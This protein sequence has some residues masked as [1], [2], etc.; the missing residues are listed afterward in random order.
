MLID[1]VEKFESIK[2]SLLS[3]MNPCVD[4][5]TTGLSI[6]GC[7]ERKR[8][9]VIGIAVDDGNDA[10]YFPFRHL[11]GTNLP[12]E[13]MNFFTKYLSDPHRTYGGW[14]YNYDLH[15]MAFDG[16]DMIPNIEDGE[17]ALHL[18]NENEPSFK[19]K[20]T[21]DRYHIGDGSLQE[22]ILEDKVFEECQK[23]G[24][25]CSR[26][27]RAANN[28]KSMMYVLPPAD[29]EPYACDDVRL[30]RQLIDLLK[31]A[32][33][34]SGLYEIWKQVNYYSYIVCLMEHRGMY[35]NKDMIERY[36]IEA[37]DKFK[38]AQLR[39]NEAAGFELNPNSPKK[40]CEFL[41]VSSSSA[42]NL[43][44]LMDA[45]GKEAE[46]A[47]LIQVA[48]GWKSVDSRYYTPYLNAIDENSTLHCSLNMIGTYTGRLS[49]SNPNLQA[50]AKHTDV[51]KV[52]DVF[53]A[54]DGYI[55]IQADYKQAEM[56][57][58]THYTKEPLMKELIEQDAD[59]HQATADRLNIPRNAAKRIN[60]S[61]IYGIGAKT[62]S[63]RLRVDQGTAK[64]YLEK[65]HGLYTGFR[66]L[67]RQCE[68][69]AK[70]N[71]YI[72]LWTGRLRHFNVP[73]ADP[74][75]AMSNLIQGG[76]A[77]I[78]RVA[79]SRLYPAIKDIGGNLLMQVHDSVII[80][81]PVDQ[82]NIALPTIKYIMEDFD[83]DPK[84]GVDIEYGFSWGLFQK[85][86]GL[87][88]DVNT[89]KHPQDIE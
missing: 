21:A 13:C 27:S 11:Q 80:E 33:N 30:T 47:K 15:M 75:K 86:D 61:V 43:E 45:G 76:V 2:P 51:F 22:S 66:R 79:I 25:E 58:V 42:E 68:D 64:E 1:T 17:L 8:D 56:R 89:L 67:M 69:F 59:L 50:V 72:E 83:F 81:V 88:V 9:V 39:L 6:F 23:L 36:R 49:C 29:V 31:P 87:D 35:V 19:L 14:N 46:N 3:C 7:K 41:G 18:I 16:I 40:V 10:Y 54:R 53:W 28:T 38:E 12:M 55:M 74:H 60:F 24:L 26:S 73:E 62:L 48:R 57:L 44:I 78:V 34:L 65:Y 85:W 37:E 5:E 70:E 82:I 77:E 4:T 52:K 84:V 63:E 71:G 32:L 20:E